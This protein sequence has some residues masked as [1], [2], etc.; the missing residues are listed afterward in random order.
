MMTL[1]LYE[2]ASSAT[3]GAESWLDKFLA[4]A[5][6]PV[7]IFL[8][9]LYRFYASELRSGV[10]DGKKVE[11]EFAQGTLGVVGFCL[12]CAVFVIVVLGI[13]DPIRSEKCPPGSVSTSCPIT[14]DSRKYDASAV[15]LLTLIW[16]GYPVVSIASRLLSI[17]EDSGVQYNAWISLFKDLTYGVLDV[18]AKGG[19]AMYSVYRSTWL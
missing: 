19:L 5:L 13:I 8:G 18:T 3:G 15:M 2:L 1:E 7:M 6:M 4:A 11:V 12:S 9:G 16:I 17:G 14:I 10:K